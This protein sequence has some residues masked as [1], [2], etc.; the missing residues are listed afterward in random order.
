MKI[1]YS[2]NAFWSNSG[3]GTQGKSLLPRLAEL[4]IV[5]GREN[6]A[7]FA[8][9]GLQGGVHQVEGF[10]VYPAGADAYGNDIIGAH[11]KNFQADV[12]IT[13]IDAWVL[14]NIQEKINPAI[15]VPWFPVDHSPVPKKV[16]KG[17]ADSNFPV[18]YSKHGLN[19]CKE[20]GREV[21]YIPHG[22]ETNTFYVVEDREIV[23]NFKR[24][25]LQTEDF[26]AVMV[27]A[28]K[29]YPDRKG[30]QQQ[31]RAFS[32]YVHEHN[33]KAKVYIHAEPTT[34]YGGIDLVSLIETLDLQNN[35]V[36]PDRYANFV[37]IPSE[38]LNMIYNA[39]DCLLGAT[40][41]EGFGI[42]IIESQSAG[43]RVIVSDFTSMPELVRKGHIVEPRDIFYTPMNSYQC[44]PDWEGVHESIVAIAKTPFSVEEQIELQNQIHAEF[45]WDIIVKEQWEPFLNKLSKNESKAPK[46]TPKVKTV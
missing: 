22:I 21:D 4:E 11:A 24:N 42:P 19:S 38:H 6:V 15:Y 25:V 5:G 45:S 26:L 12:V 29:G 3:Y 13:L 1:L 39:A 8:W 44:I 2:S 20:A 28:N 14:E 7:M 16:L 9:Y 18:T 41:G 27:A 35:V 36:M 31:L 37:G 30:F 32:K 43:T 40:M 17:I 33:P 10:T 23:E 46:H 34:Q